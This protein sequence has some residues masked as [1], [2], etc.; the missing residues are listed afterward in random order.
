MSPL[1]KDFYDPIIEFLPPE[2]VDEEQVRGVRGVIIRRADRRTLFQYE[3]GT[4]GPLRGLPPGVVSE[5]YANDLGGISVGFGCDTKY[6]GNRCGEVR[7]EVPEFGE[8]GFEYSFV[9]RV[10]TSLSDEVVWENNLAVPKKKRLLVR[11][12]RKKSA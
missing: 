7:L 1:E 11:E 3:S 12:R 10:R 8:L 2:L 5:V 9:A 6:I 4:L